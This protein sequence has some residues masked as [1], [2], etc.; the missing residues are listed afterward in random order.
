MANFTLRP[1]YRKERS[2]G[3]YWIGSW[4]G[5]RSGLDDMEKLKFDPTGTRTLTMLSL[6]ELQKLLQILAYA[7]QMHMKIKTAQRVL[8]KM[9]PYFRNTVNVTRAE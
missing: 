6:L 1:L 9:L 5:P 2:Y 8:K 7:R 4:V 3:T